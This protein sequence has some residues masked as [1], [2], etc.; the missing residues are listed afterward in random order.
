LENDPNTSVNDKEITELGGA[1]NWIDASTI[2]ASALLTSRASKLASL[3][4]TYGY[5]YDYG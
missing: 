3:C 1:H 2:A 4:Q 5:L